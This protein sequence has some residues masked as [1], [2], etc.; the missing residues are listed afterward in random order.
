LLLYIVLWFGSWFSFDLRFRLYVAA[1]FRLVYGGLRFAVCGCSSP[2]AYVCCAARAAGLVRSRAATF[3]FGLG[4]C[5]CCRVIS[6]FRFTFTLPLRRLRFAFIA[7]TPV[8]FYRCCRLRYVALRLRDAGL[9]ALVFAY[10]VQFCWFGLVVTLRLRCSVCAFDRFV[11][12][13]LVVALIRWLFVTVRYGCY[14]LQY[15]LRC[16]VCPR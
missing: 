14:A 9:P 8:Q 3:H 11:V 12:V 5:R 6:W 15:W 16:R 2:F 13:W 1:R 7:S 4:A 10:A